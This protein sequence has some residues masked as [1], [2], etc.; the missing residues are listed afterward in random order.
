M[1][2]TPKMLRKAGETIYGR[3]WQVR[4][5]ADVGVSRRTMSRY[6]NNTD[7]CQWMIDEITRL[8]RFYGQ[9]NFDLA[10]MMEFKI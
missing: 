1:K 6:A 2:L 8:A 9:R 10:D 4:L 5:A 7:R 3:D